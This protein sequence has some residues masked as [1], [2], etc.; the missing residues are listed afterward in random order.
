MGGHMDGEEYRSVPAVQQRGRSL[1]S[2]AWGPRNRVCPHPPR[3]PSWEPS[4]TLYSIAQE[5]VSFL[6]LNRMSTA[7]CQD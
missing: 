3:L 4:L 7:K 6:P 1:V 5:V 2:I